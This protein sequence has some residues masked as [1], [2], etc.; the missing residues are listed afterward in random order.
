MDSESNLFKTP[1]EEETPKSSQPFF[2]EQVCDNVCD[3]ISSRVATREVDFAVKVSGHEEGKKLML[4]GDSFQ[5]CQ[6][7][8]NL[9]D[10]GE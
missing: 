1:G 10:N 6:C 7:L 3:M 8:V 4:V 2:L 9:C 5:L